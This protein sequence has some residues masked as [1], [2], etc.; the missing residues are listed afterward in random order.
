MN[1]KTASIGSDGQL[2]KTTNPMMTLRSKVDGER[3]LR[4]GRKQEIRNYI[5]NT[6][7]AFSFF[8]FFVVK[9]LPN[10]K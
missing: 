3:R 10:K 1:E 9:L 7:A 8:F 2:T 5:D 6:K 4:H